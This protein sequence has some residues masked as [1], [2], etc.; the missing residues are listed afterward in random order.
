MRWPWQRK[1]TDS[2]VTEKATAEKPISWRKRLPWPLLA[3]LIAGVVIVLFLISRP[4]DPRFVIVVT[5][6]ADQDGRTGQQIANALARQLRNQGANLVHVV[7][8]ETKPTNGAEALALAR[9]TNADLLVWG[10]VAAGGMIDSS[11]LSPEIIYTPH[12]IDISQAWYGFPIR[13]VIP[14]RYVISTEPINGQTILTPYL[15]ALAAYHHGEADLALDQLQSLVEN[16]P[17]LHP[18]LLHVLRGNLLWARGWYGAAATEYQTA[19]SLAQGERALLANNLGAILLDAG[20]AEAPRYFAEAINLLDGRDLGQLRVNLALWAL[21]E[22]RASDAV[23]DLEQ[24]RNL[25][26][27]DPELELLIATA[28]RESG[29]IAEAQSSLTRF[30]A[31]RATTAARVPVAFRSA[32]ETRLNA[33]FSEERALTALEAR[34]PMTGPFYWALATAN[35]IPSADTLRQTRDQLRV[36]TEQSNRAVTLW[37]QQAASQAA[38]FPGS[39]LMATGQAERSEELARRQRLSLALTEAVLWSVENSNRQNPFNQFIAALFG[40]VGGGNPSVEALRQLREQQPDDVMTLLAL[41]FALRM[42]EQYDE[43]VQTYQRVIELAPQLPDGYA[44][45]GM[46]A[47]VRNDRESAQQWLRQALDRNNRFFPAHLL[48]A[49]VAEDTGDWS[50]AVNHWRALV[51]WQETPYTVV[52][53]ARAL[54]RSGA[55]GFAEAERLLVP[56]ATEHVEATIELARL[57]NDA[58]YPNEAVSVYR[59]ALVLDPRSTVAAFE[60]GETYIRLG[61]VATAERM[62]RDALTFDERNLDA[63]LRL[64]E[65]YEGP[66]NQPDRAIEQYRIALGQ[67][68]NDLDRLIR[69]GQAALAGN[70]TTVA[71]QA[72]ERA[73]TGN[74][75]SATVNQLLARAYLNGN[76]LEAAA[77]TAQRTLDLTANRTD[78]E[79]IS[80]RVNAFLALAE[81]ARRRN[82]LAAAEQ[83]YQQAIAVDPQSIP[84]HIGLGELA[85]GQGNWGVALAYFET[86]AALPGGDMNA[87][88]QFWLGEAL[89]RND[90]L[91]RALAAYQRALELQPQ[92]PEALLGLAQTQYALGR[93]EEAL[94]TVERAIQQKSNYAEAHLFRGKLLQEAGRF[95]EARAAYDAAIGAN[96]RIAE[97]FYRRALLAI[98][99]G[100][101]DQAI[102]DLNRATALQAN[103]PE[104]YYWLGRAYYAQGRSESALQAIQQAITL[105]PNYS[106]AIFYS[107]LIAEDQ[108]N[109][110]A[111]RDAYQTLISREPTSEWGQRALAQIERLP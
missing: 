90:N 63:R 22:Q 39:G 71:I 1:P 72:L 76:R 20:N 80:A 70:A 56:L 102:R 110:A 26:S 86:A 49:Q 92:Y 46:V 107:G 35:P 61:D 51:N 8:S 64:A 65:L 18:L 97:S 101:Y 103:F 95:A 11:S 93:A 66:I 81:I 52:H 10:T 47:L 25:L 83:A 77:Q 27:P 29:R 54:R 96:D 33:V 4:A 28:Y 62:L 7:L 89:L 57:Y 68:V 111:A 84:A 75:E 104:A 16:N 40:A 67:G 100:E 15:L 24:A 53:L 32:Y 58:G 41:G 74:P 73:L 31:T 19:L 38:I 23:S 79:A 99:N 91:A 45:I 34:L 109:F 17:Q 87:A 9:Q 60:L 6:F 55:S 13:L 106:E 108:A 105:N 21:R 94:Q 2:V 12:N 85:G 42:D 36:A 30:E 3:L 69:I 37:R 78:P 14:N 50:S 82:D 59:D 88:A 44:G 5:P 43:A 48:L 98:R